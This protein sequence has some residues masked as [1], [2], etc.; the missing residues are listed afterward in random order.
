[1]LT[2]RASS[3]LLFP[4]GLWRSKG[5]GIHSPFAFSLI[6]DTLTPGYRYYAYDDIDR[7]N[8]PESRRRLMKL[9]VRLLARFAPST[10][11]L[12]GHDEAL[13][14][15]VASQCPSAV[16]VTDPADC[17][18]CDFTIVTDPSQWRPDAVSVAGSGVTDARGFDSPEVILLADSS[19]APARE[20]W[21]QL[22]SCGSY[23]TFEG[24]RS[25]LAVRRQGLPPQ[26]FKL[27]F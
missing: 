18:Q 20:L 25:A 19:G 21:R 12:C 3:L 4:L 2:S 9:V 22:L 15:L 23:M 1:M 10:V 17:R 7:M 14:S 5:H 6:T 11:R 26:S 27:I 24:W 16:I 8:Q 13:A